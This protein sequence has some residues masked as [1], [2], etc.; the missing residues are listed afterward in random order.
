MAEQ[1][2]LCSGKGKS[3]GDFGATGNGKGKAK[4]KGQ[5]SPR[6]QVNIMED[7]Y[8]GQHEGADGAASHHECEWQQIGMLICSRGIPKV[9]EPKGR[10]RRQ[11]TASRWCRNPRRRTAAQT[12]TDSAARGRP[13]ANTHD[14]KL[15]IH[16]TPTCK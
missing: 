3:K 16:G 9:I 11:P 6:P 1:L 13:R 4:G 10:R 8:Y 12:K 15:Q 5:Y 14:P 2:A 7:Y